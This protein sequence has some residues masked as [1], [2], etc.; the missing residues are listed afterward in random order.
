MLHRV[1]GGP[2]E[3]HAVDDG[4]DD[5]AAPHELADGVAHILI[6]AA[7]AVHP[8]HYQRVAC[9]QHVIEPFALS[10]FRQFGSDA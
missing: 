5:D 2:V 4:A 6:V 8:A 3:G 7:K 1:L 9:P 10:P